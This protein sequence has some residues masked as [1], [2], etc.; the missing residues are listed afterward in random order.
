MPRDTGHCRRRGCMCTHD[1]PCEY[2]WLT[3]PALDHNG[4]TYDRVAPC[5][6]CRPAA[7]TRLAE[8]LERTSRSVR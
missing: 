8:E 7:A 6:I 5:P 2:G 1:H 4:E 3:M